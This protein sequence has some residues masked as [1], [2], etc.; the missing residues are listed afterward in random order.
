MNAI[1]AERREEEAALYVGLPQKSS[2]LHLVMMSER[3]K[4]TGYNWKWK[5]CC[6]SLRV[7]LW[8][9]HRYNDARNGLPNV[10]LSPTL[11]PPLLFLNFP[12]LRHWSHTSTHLL[13]Y[14]RHDLTAALLSTMAHFLTYW[15][16]KIARI[17]LP[18]NCSVTSMSYI[19]DCAPKF[20]IIYLF[21]KRWIRYWII[22]YYQLRC[23]NLIWAIS[24][25][26]LK[27]FQLTKLLEY[28]Y[29]KVIISNSSST[30]GLF[31]IYAWIS[32]DWK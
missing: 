6:C 30:V 26:M 11:L 3:Q 31:L 5:Y 23:M 13:V 7:S 9:H 14:I 19:S 20:D 17:L 1:R 18:F 29:A 32:R 24:V 2:R 15:L 28:M 27:K 21:S 10:Q 16:Y 8:S 22:S 25:R 12:S 4:L